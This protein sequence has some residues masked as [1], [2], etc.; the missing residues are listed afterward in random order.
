MMEL[1]GKN[2]TAKVF[3]NNIDGKTIEQVITM[4][5]DPITENTQVRIMPDTHYGAGATIGT[6]IKLPDNLSYWKIA[7]QVVGVDLSCGMMSVKITEKDIDL[8]K[9]DEVVHQVV[10][11]GNRVHA[12]PQAYI[13]DFIEKLSF[14]PKRS[15]QHKKGL[16]TLGGGNHFIELSVDEAGNYW[17]TVH[18]GS[19]SFGAEIARYHEQIAKK[20]HSDQTEKIKGI[21]SSLKLQG[22]E[23][24]IEKEI[25]AFKNN[26]T[27]PLIPYLK[28]ELLKDYLHDISLADNYANFSRMIM[29]ENIVKEMNW[30]VVDSFDSVH[31]NIDV[32]NG[33]IRKGA[34]SAFKGERLIIPLN[35][36]DGSLICVGKGNADWNYSAPHGAGRVLSRTAARQQL[37]LS[38]YKKQMSDVYTSSVNIN[39]IDEAPAVYK[40]AKEIEMLIADTVD[41]LHRLKPVYNFKAH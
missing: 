18:S 21:I 2:A 35:M 23:K 13:D 38:D 6:T 12:T 15:E 27:I 20:Y 30:T 10:P 22:R 36:R 8:K 29:L 34:T 4:L 33:I 5:N 40:Q 11:A 24:D 32:K 37:D 39:T 31:N 3:T 16:G 17:L 1:G 26:H 19:R 28:G 9:L 41:V 7:P 14:V 25:I